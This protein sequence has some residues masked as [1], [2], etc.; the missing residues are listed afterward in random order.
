M[1][2]YHLHTMRCGHATGLP[3]EYLL[4]AEEIGLQEI[5]FS[6]HF[7]LGLLDHKP[8]AKVTM[9]P[10]ELADYIQDIEK[11]K[12]QSRIMKI[13]VGVEIDYFPEA[14]EKISRLLE[15]YAFDYVIGSIHFIGEWDF[16]HP[17]YAEDYRN[18]DID[19]LYAEYFKLIEKACRS[20]LFDIIGHIDVIKKF[21][22]RPDA[23]LDLLWLKMANVLKRTGT[24]IELNT[25]GRDAPVDEFYPNRSMLEACLVENVPLTLGS[26]AH[27]PEQVGRYFP[28]A[29][30]LLSEVG[31]R[32]LAIFEKRV[33][34]SVAL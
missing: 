30:S 22:Y 16:T 14:E 20:R 9:E 32:E 12:E 13:K 21:G 2:D 34:S 26:D 7:P 6:D 1:I 11:L 25:S 10:E 24:C 4:R 33:R 27:S 31:C 5:G 15:E 23:D 3:E 28:E 18:L 17:A 8:K 19:R 29:K